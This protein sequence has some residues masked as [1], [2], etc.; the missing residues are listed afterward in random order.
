[1]RRLILSLAAALAL[2][3]CGRV[4]TITLPGGPTAAGVAAGVRAAAAAATPPEGYARLFSPA[5]H[6]FRHSAA[7]EPVRAGR[8]SERY[9]LR[10]GDCG[11]SDCGAARA[12]AEIAQVPGSAG[13][14]LDRD[15]WYGWSFHNATIGSVTR[16]RWLGTVIG[17]WK[18]EGEAP[19]IFRLV[20][21]PADEDGFAR[22]D[23]GICTGGSSAAEDVVIELD[24]MAAAYGWGAAQN[25]GRIC[26]LFGME[27]NRGR[28]VDLVV[29]TNFGTDGFG[30]LRVWVNGALR[31]SYQGQLVPPGTAK[32]GAGPLVRRG[33]FNSY[34]ERW[35]RT[36]GGAPKPT[37]IA[38]YDEF[39]TGASRAE[40]DPGLRTAGMRAVD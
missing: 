23:P 15:I 38:Y 6:A 18:A 16:D 2:A 28:W 9:E 10:D 34:M 35:N 20:Q 33:I 29:N 31:C 4:I 5:P 3:A 12:R 22:C 14:A 39:R 40:V 36:Q 21:V 30:Y 17:Q 27:A 32:G 24:A 8:V 19:A 7:G 26:R 1:L 25:Q 11:G 37:L 13:A